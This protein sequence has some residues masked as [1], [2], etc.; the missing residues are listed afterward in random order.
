MTEAL[1][2]HG[3]DVNA[4]CSSGTAL[5]LAV[6]SGFSEVARLL[7]ERGADAEIEQ[8]DASVLQTPLLTALAYQELSSARV[9]L[10]AGAD[11]NHGVRD[12]S[13]L[14]L[15]AYYLEDEEAVRL[16][17]EFSPGPDVNI[18]DTVG[19]T[20]LND[21]SGD[22]HLPIVKRLVNYGADVE[23]A[24]ATGITPLYRAINNRQIEVVEYL[25]S[26]KANVNIVLR[27]SGTA[28]H[29]A[30]RRADLEI[31]KLVAARRG[32]DVNRGCDEMAGTPLMSALWG[33]ASP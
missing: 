14:R 4:V 8:P 32:I 6:G 12:N 11:V 9:L 7:L 10:E 30:C 24:N 20:V 23:L 13:P 18:Q 3:A 2:D 1:L 16:L 5:R 33:I 28:L 19:D 22:G 31:V 17:L 15:A 26:R 25:L 29:L 21:A 27:Q